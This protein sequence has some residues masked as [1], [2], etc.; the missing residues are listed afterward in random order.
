MNWNL[1]D[2]LEHIQE[3]IGEPA[4]GYYNL[5]SRLR[6]INLAQRELCHETRAIQDVF[7][8]STITDQSTYGLPSNFL[9]YGKESPY[10]VE[11]GGTTGAIKVV[12]PGWMDS[13][14]PGWRAE[15]SQT[16]RGTPQYI[17]NRT[18]GE[19]TLHPTPGRVQ[20]VRIP[21][22]VDPDELVNLEDV[23]FN[24][25]SEL[26]RFSLAIAYKVASAWFMPR[27]PDLGSRYN[28]LAKEQ[29]RLMRSAMQ[30]NPQQPIQIRPTLYKNRGRSGG[31]NYGP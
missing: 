24:G 3:L 7:D 16:T 25:I 13:A 4:G 12:T 14:F 20:T 22:V 1:E 18:S 28:N 8:L 11:T 23:P 27:A 21:Y 2:I 31:G 17:V 19:F 9:T 30:S 26:N 5:S 15:G 29:E 6:Q 10:L